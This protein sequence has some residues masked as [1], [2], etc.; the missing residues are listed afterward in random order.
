MASGRALL[1][2]V[3]DDDLS[4]AVFAHVLKSDEVLQE[5]DTLHLLH[6]IISDPSASPS[7]SIPSA[8]YFGIVVWGS[9][10]PPCRVLW[11]GASGRAAVD[12]QPRRRRKTHNNGKKK[13]Q[14]R[15]TPRPS[16]APSARCCSAAF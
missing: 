6:V 2:P 11:C 8:D 1:L 9:L 15:P 16:A 4:E 3:D 10:E 14:T 5:G 7:A 12:R 13:N